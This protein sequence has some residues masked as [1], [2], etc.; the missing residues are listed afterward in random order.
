MEKKILAIVPARGGSKGLPGK[1][2][3]PLLHKP[4]IGWTLEQV[5]EAKMVDEAFVS[6]DDP[7]IASVAKEF[8]FEPPYLRPKDLATDTSPTIDVIFH[9]LDY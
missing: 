4:L 1:N 2:I 9:T 7:D 8:G 3:K 6:T 5:K